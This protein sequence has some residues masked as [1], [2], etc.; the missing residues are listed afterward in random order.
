MVDSNE[1][2]DELRFTWI[3]KNIDYEIHFIHDN[4]QNKL[5]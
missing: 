5:N 2:V 1:I 3:E 4:D